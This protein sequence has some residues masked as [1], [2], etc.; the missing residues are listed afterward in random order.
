MLR[1]LRFP[2]LRR[3]LENLVAEFLI[4][5]EVRKKIDSKN[6]VDPALGMQ[7]VTKDVK[8]MQLNP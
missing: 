5:E 3:D 7:I 8:T 2:E 6:S 4:R 1:Y